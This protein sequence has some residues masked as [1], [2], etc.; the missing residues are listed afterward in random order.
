MMM[1]IDTPYLPDSSMSE[2][3][4]SNT[5]TFDQVYQRMCEMAHERFTYYDTLFGKAGFLAENMAKEVKLS[6]YQP[7]YN[8]W[9]D[10][11]DIKFNEFNQFCRQH[12]LSK[13]KYDLLS[14][15][16]E[17]SYAED[18]YLNYRMG[19]SS[20][21]ISWTDNDNNFFDDGP[22]QHYEYRIITIE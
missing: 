5:E 18:C 11:E 19:N 12:L 20:V 16:L 8:E 21:L 1:N 14:P 17:Y 3:F 15:S 10:T 13:V 9:S 4:R 7:N 6:G 22:Y 2:V